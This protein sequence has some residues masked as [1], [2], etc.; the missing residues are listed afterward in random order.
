MPFVEKRIPAQMISH[1]L[2]LL[3]WSSFFFVRKFS[4]QE[5]CVHVETELV[6]GFKR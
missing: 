1:V 3:N 2:F 5:R 4:H 6:C